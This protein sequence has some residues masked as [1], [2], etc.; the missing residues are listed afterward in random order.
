MI[1]ANSF[2]CNFDVDVF[3]NTLVTVT[4]TKEGKSIRRLV[5]LET[6]MK[7]IKGNCI[8]VQETQNYSHGLVPEGLVTSFSDSEGGLGA[9]IHV[10]K[11]KHFYSNSKSKYMLPY[12][13]LLFFY[14]IK[15][16]NIKQKLCFAVKDKKI[17]PKTRLYVYPYGNV[18]TYDGEICLGSTKLLKKQSITT[19]DM[20][21]EC[22]HV[23]FNSKTDNHYYNPGTSTTIMKDLDSL[24]VHVNE[25]GVFPDESLIPSEAGSVTK[26]IASCKEDLE[27]IN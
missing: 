27:C 4:A 8:L 17:T 20:I 18:S 19:Y 21:S 3:G 22:I 1:Q 13:G 15:N 24:V 14:Y 12:P 16:N 9:L 5:D 10:G 6:C 2:N 23:F 11:G 26:L 25:L 7:M